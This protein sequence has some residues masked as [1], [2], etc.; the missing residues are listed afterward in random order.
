MYINTFV[1]FAPYPPFDFGFP[2]KKASIL[3]QNKGKSGI[4][5]WTHIESGKCYVG[6]AVDLSK[7][8]K[9][10]FNVYYLKREITV[11]RSLI[12]RA[13]LKY[14]YT[15]FT[16]EIVEYCE[17]DKVLHREQYYLDKIKPEYNILN[18]AGSVL[19]LKHT[20]EA[21]EAIR[22]SKLGIPLSVERRLIAAISSATALP[23]LVTE[24]KTNNNKT[25]TSIRAAANYIGIHHSYLAE[26]IKSKGLYSSNMYTVKLLEEK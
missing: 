10:Y 23:V 5:K 19:G 13:L 18:T 12:Y 4:Y 17:K 16:L 20:E 7:R 11:S 22:K 26:C 24:V 6:S 9:N 3:K 25:F 14:G 21:I 2:E 1:L 8:F 15:S